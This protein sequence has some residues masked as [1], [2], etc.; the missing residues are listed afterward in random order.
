MTRGHVAVLLCGY[1]IGERSAR[2]ID[3]SYVRR[4]LPR[5]AARAGVD[6]RV[7]A[8]GLRHTADA[9]LAR[10]GTPINVIGDALGHSTP[11]VTD[12]YLLAVGPMHV[13]DTIRARAGIARSDDGRGRGRQW[14]LRAGPLGEASCLYLSG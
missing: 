2:R 6:R 11:A 1:A 3:P 4:L 10:E 12:R 13:I 8:H 9:E 7:H 14:G 5:L